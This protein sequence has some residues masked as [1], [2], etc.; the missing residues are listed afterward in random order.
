MR[1]F[2]LPFLFLLSNTLFSNVNQE[3]EREEV[4]QKTLHFFE[5]LGYKPISPFPLYSKKKYGAETDYF[6]YCAEGNDLP[7]GTVLIQPCARMEDFDS[8]NP[9]VLP[10]HYQLSFNTEGGS[11]KIIDDALSYL[12]EFCKADPKK[13]GIVSIQSD[14]NNTILGLE[15]Y[16]PYF[17]SYGVEKEHILLRNPQEAVQEGAGDGYWKHPEYTHLKGETFAIYY[18]QNDTSPSIENYLSRKDWMEIA[19]GGY[20]YKNLEVSFGMER[21]EHEFFNIP[22]PDKEKD[23]QRIKRLSSEG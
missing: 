16:I 18:S 15:A 22:Y 23:R 1:S 5:N 11:K 12:F 2:L 7:I 13:I 3:R 8:T 17:L 4:Q 6:R 21:I 19:E 20:R 9:F 10:I 14:P